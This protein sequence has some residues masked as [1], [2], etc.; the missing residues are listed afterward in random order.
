[1]NGMNRTRT[2][3]RGGWRATA[4]AVGVSLVA[5][6]SALAGPGPG[7]AMERLARG[8]AAGARREYE[9]LLERT[10]KDPRLAFNAGVAAHQMGDW[11]AAAR[12]HESA[13]TS[14]DISLQQKA[15]FG[16]GSARFR[17]GEAATEPSEKA[18]LWEES[19][20]SFH[21]AM[22]LGPADTDA[23]ANYEAVREQLAQIGRA[24]V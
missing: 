14:P 20:R 15:F 3:R 12:H 5:C 10:P 9:Q 19:A 1:M 11:D 7:A 13:M 16:L 24:H 2:M 6:L 18:R 8:D 21:A 17:Q 22:G 4:W 23:R